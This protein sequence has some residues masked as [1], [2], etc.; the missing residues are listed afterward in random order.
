VEWSFSDNIPG[1]RVRGSSVLIATGYGLDGRSS[2]PGR[3]KRISL[4]LSV[5]TG[6]R[7]HPASYPIVTGAVLPGGKWQGCEADHSAPSNA[8]VKTGGTVP[9]L[10]H[11]SS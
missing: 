4:L 5:Q 11:M 6:S 3:G 2:I 9:P 10:P 8:E 7:A 1:K